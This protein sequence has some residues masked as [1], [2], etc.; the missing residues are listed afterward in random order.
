MHPELLNNSLFLRY[1][2][3]WQDNPSSIVFASIAE[4]F[5]M[6]GMVDAAMKVCR[7]GLKRHPDL[8]SGRIVMARVHL[9]RG[10]WEEA[11]GELARVMAQVPGNK[12][13]K[14]M[15]EEV[16]RLRREEREGAVRGEA[17]IASGGDGDAHGGGFA[18]NTVTMA[19][20]FASQGHHAKAREIY[21][22]ILTTDPDNEAARAGIASLPPAV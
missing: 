2:K 14:R 1:Y 10:N 18:W 16:A 5:L 8:V 21:Q 22:S 9:R 15:M 12:A 3:Q 17:E 6:Y 11:E 20:I 19:D 13:A 7:E 4:Y